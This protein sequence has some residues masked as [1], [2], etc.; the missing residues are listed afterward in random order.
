MAFFGGAAS[1]R[2]SPQPA[3]PAQPSGGPRAPQ[4][5]PAKI[6]SAEDEHD[7]L[8]ELVFGNGAWDAAV[9]TMDRGQFQV[10]GTYG[11]RVDRI[12]MFRSTNPSKA[13]TILIAVEKTVLWVEEEP[14]GEGTG[15][16]PGESVVY[17][18]RPMIKQSMA[19]F[20]KWLAKVLDV[21]VDEIGDDKARWVTH[22]S[23]PLGGATILRERIRTSGLGEEK[24]PFTFCDVLEPL[25]A[26]A[27]V[28]WRDSSP[29][30]ARL[31]ARLFPDDLIEQL[32]VA[33]QEAMAQAQ[34][35][36]EQQ[37]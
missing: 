37:G 28:E 24:R 34:A 12:H 16:R 19:S 29:E 13:Q 22:P 18:Y 2:P 23:N 14:K 8:C 35:Q 10:D 21:P 25:P 11:V 15:N 36:T 4:Q 6:R 32:M 20:K 9:P 31:A 33:E 30:A 5:P 1:K 27:L 17:F 7:M 26:E 3:R